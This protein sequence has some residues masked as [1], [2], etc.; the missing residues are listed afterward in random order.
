MNLILF[1]AAPAETR[2]CITQI[3]RRLRMWRESTGA[4]KGRRVEHIIALTCPQNVRELILLVLEL[5]GFLQLCLHGFPLSCSL[6]YLLSCRQSSHLFYRRWIRHQHLRYFLL[7]RQ[8]STQSY[9]LE[10]LRFQIKNATN[11]CLA[12]I[13]L[14]HMPVQNVF[15]VPSGH[16]HPRLD[17]SP[18]PFV[19]RVKRL[20][21]RRQHVNSALQDLL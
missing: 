21:L 1:G 11:V 8:P 12:I 2:V 7:H 18:V 15:L 10:V 5:L 13:A 19:H 20:P 14:C 3:G 16:F 17:Q 4:Q 6:D 9:V